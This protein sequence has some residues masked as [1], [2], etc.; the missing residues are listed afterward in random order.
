[1][2]KITANV[3][4]L[5]GV[6]EIAIDG[7][8]IVAVTPSSTETD[9]YI[10]P[11][12]FDIQVNGYGGVSCWDMTDPESGALAKISGMF[13]EQGVGLWIPTVITNHHEA[14]L[15]IFTAIGKELDADPELEK[16]IPGL[17]LEGPYISKVDGPRGV[18]PLECVR[19]GSWDEF[20]QYQ[21][22]SGGRIRYVTL[23]PEVDG[24]I[25]FIKKCVEAG[26]IV[27]IGHSD[28][29]RESMN[30]AVE[31]GVSLSTHLGNGAHDMIQRHN[32][33]IWYQLAARKTYAAFISDGQHLPSECMTAMIHAKGLE[34]SVIT[35]DCVGLG[36]MPAGIYGDVE[37]LPNGRL[38]ATGTPNLAG[39][40][41]NLRECV[42]QVVN[43]TDLSHAQGWRLGSIQAAKAMGLPDKLGIE[44]G[45]EASITVYKRPDNDYKI[46]IV[47]TWVA[48]KKLFA[49]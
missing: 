4:L 12:L 11:T 6:F 23:A 27:S 32:N 25:D 41:S 40:S 5:D 39:S 16:S 20:T 1:M 38:V 35:S 28:L 8:K 47:E 18:H 7:E 2:T 42:E 26:V 34:R 9:L 30:K 31:A 36:G 29:D 46:D 14:L 13:L 24:N 17:H 44:V 3:P 43:L 15:E 22:A 19:P 10:G 49:K 21:T 45:K 37:K 33:Y 48:G